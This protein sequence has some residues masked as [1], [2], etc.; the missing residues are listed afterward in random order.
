[1]IG[2]IFVQGTVRQVKEGIVFFIFSIISN[3]LWTNFD[4]SLCNNG[5]GIFP[6][7]RMLHIHNIHVSLHT[8]TCTLH[9]INHWIFPCNIME[10]GQRLCTWWPLN[11]LLLIHCSWILLQVP[12]VKICQALRLFTWICWPS[13]MSLF[14]KSWPTLEQCTQTYALISWNFLSTNLQRNLH[15]KGSQTRTDFAPCPRTPSSSGI[16]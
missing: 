3:F 8:T 11:F 1:M 13:L 12:L 14:L 15:A 2:S 4:P 5:R 16:F 10:R 6:P 9:M 7:G